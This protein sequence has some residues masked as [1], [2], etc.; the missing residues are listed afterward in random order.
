MRARRSG[1]VVNVSSLSGR[2]PAAPCLGIYAA[3]KF[4]LGA[5]S[6][7]LRY[8]SAVHGIRVI[9]IELGTHRTNVEANLPAV[10]LGSP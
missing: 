2:V 5:L 8:E 4:A 1:I 7:A 6:E 10:N 3:S 9:L